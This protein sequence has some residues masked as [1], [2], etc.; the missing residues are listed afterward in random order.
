VFEKYTGIIADAPAVISDAS[1]CFDKC[2][3]NRNTIIMIDVASM[4]GIIFSTSISG[5]INENIVSK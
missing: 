2:S 4:L 3:E 5:I 1:S